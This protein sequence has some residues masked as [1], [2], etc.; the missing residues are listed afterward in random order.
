MEQETA[1]RRAVR[2]AQAGEAEAA[3]RKPLGKALE[4]HMDAIY[5]T[6]SMGG[7]RVSQIS[8]CKL[9]RN[10]FTLL[11]TALRRET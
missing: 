10:A 1:M 11:S 4:K 9:S 5:P 6:D 3:R 2:T 8:G 7:M